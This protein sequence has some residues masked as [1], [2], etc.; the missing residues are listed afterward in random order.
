MKQLKRFFTI[1]RIVWFGCIFLCISAFFKKEINTVIWHIHHSSTIKFEN[2]TVI[3]PWDWMHW[4][5]KTND[6]SFVHLKTGATVNIYKM[7]I[8][9][10]NMTKTAHDLMRLTYIDGKKAFWGR[11]KSD[12]KS[13][14][15]I[16]EYF[17]IPSE[18]ISIS[19]FGAKEDLPIIR[20][21]LSNIFF[22]SENDFSWMETRAQ[23]FEIIKKQKELIQQEIL[24]QKDTIKDKIL[25]AHEF[26]DWLKKYKVLDEN[27]ILKIP[28]KID[29]PL[30]KDAE[31]IVTGV[32]DGYY[33]DLPQAF[34]ESGKRVAFAGRIDLLNQ[35]NVWM[36][37]IWSLIKKGCSDFYI[38]ANLANTKRISDAFF[39]NDPYE[40]LFGIAHEAVTVQT[41]TLYCIN[42]PVGIFIPIYILD[43]FFQEDLVDLVNSKKKIDWI[44]ELQGK[45]A[46]YL[47]VFEQES[48]VFNEMYASLNKNSDD[49]LIISNFLKNH[50]LSAYSGEQRDYDLGTRLFLSSI[51]PAK[52]DKLGWSYVMAQYPYYAH[53]EAVKEI[54]D[55]ALEHHNGDI[56][57]VCRN[58]TAMKTSK[59]QYY[60]TDKDNVKSALNELKEILLK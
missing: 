29:T 15:T 52:D 45:K 13:N 8:S 35:D 37:M 42:E 30:I 21:M 47:N 3:L 17:F 48:K 51:A 24:K 38:R 11:K 26:V 50:Y 14:E 23:S 6:Y 1:K 2:A 25:L 10:Q 49:K 16:E 39:L 53:Y 36:N 22:T 54:V 60:K 46:H 28:L 58:Y 44:K 59:D 57:R 5:K 7:D 43:K 41:H 27:D 19:C 4:E 33:P 9:T 31:A 55:T 32:V 12:E 20:K 34:D 40:I 56:F 18:G